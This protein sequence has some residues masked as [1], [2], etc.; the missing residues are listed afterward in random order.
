MASLITRLLSRFKT[1][2]RSRRNR[3]QL[4]RRL[5]V[6]HMEARR[7][8]AGDLG[9]IAGNVF[10][11]LADDGYQVSDVGIAGVTVSLFQDAPGAGAGT[12]GAEDGA[13]IQTNVTD[14]NGNYRFNGLSSIDDTTD[15]LY[16]VQQSAATGKL[17]R[18]AES[19]KS[20]TITPAM[21]NG[22]EATNIDTY[23]TTPV[24]TSPL[25]AGPGGTASDQATTAAGEALGGERDIQVN[26]TTVL[27]SGSQNL[28]VAV[29]GGLLSIS[30]DFGVTGSVIVSYDGV[31]LSADTLDHTT[32]PLTDLTA[33][34]GEAFEFLVGSQPGNSLTVSV[35]SGGTNFS[36][37]TVPLP[38]TSVGPPQVNLIIPFA[39]LVVAGGTGVTLTGVTA[40]RFQVDVAAGQDAQI[41]FTSVVAADVTTRNFANLNPMSL[42]N[43]VFRD[44]NNNGMKDAGDPGIPGVRVELYEDTNANGTYDTGI[45]TAVGTAQTTDA[46]GNYLFSNLLPG[47]YIALVPIS[48]FAAGQALEGL[49]TSTGND[50]TPDPDINVS[51]N[52]DN[53]A[54]IAGVGVATAAITLASGTE[55]TNDGD[56]DNNSNLTLDF[57]FAPQ[58]DLGVVKTANVTTV[59]AGNQ[60]TYTL[61]VTNAGP[62]AATNVVVTDNL[63]N[64]SPDALVIVSATA[65]GGGV[66]TQPGNANG[67]VE[68][69]YASL[70]AGQTETVTIIVRV[71]AAAAA[72]AAITN[73]ATIIGEGVEPTPDNVNIN[74]DSLDVAVTRQAVLTLT[75]TDAPDPSTVGGTLTYTILVT[76]TGPSTATNVVVSDT[77]PAGLTYVSSDTTA[78]AVAHATGVITATIPTLA[79]SASATVTIVT[80]IQASFAGSTIPNSAT[81]QADDAAQ[82]TANATTAVNPDIDLQ[83][84][85]DDDVDPVNRGGV[86]VYTLTVFNDGPSGA[87]NVE[88]VDTLPAGVTFVS[89]TGGTVTGGTVGTNGPVT[90]DLGSMASKQ[91]KVI[92]LTV[93]VAS[94]AAASI[95]N[96]AI[97]RS[98]ESTAGFDRDTTNNTATEPTA[99]Q[100]TIDLELTKTASAASVKPGQSLVYTI[101]VTNKGPSDATLVSLTDNIPDGIRITS[102]TSTVGTVTIPASAQDTTAANADD[103]T[104]NIGNLVKDATVTI[105]VN[106]TVLPGTTGSITNTANVSTTDTS[107]IETITANNTGS[108]TTTLTPEID[109]AIT[110]TD[111]VDPATAGSPLTYTITVTNSGPST[112]TNVNVTDNLPTGVSFTSGSASQGTVS[113]A[114]GV[115]TGNLGTLAPGASATMTIIVGV[116]AATRGTIT[117]TV[118]VVGAETEPITNNNS[119]SQDTVING[120]VDLV[121]TKVD[122][123][124]PVA[125]GGALS[126]TIEVTNNG[127]S[128]ATNVVV[129]DNLPTTLA[130]VSGNSTVGTVTNAGN[131]VT[132]NVGT[133]ASGAKAIITVNTTVSGTATGTITNT[134]SVVAA[135]AESNTAN[136]SATQTT[137]LV[138]PGSISGFAY[139]DVNRNGTRDNG[140]TPLPNVAVALSGTE[141]G[142]GTAVTRQTTTDANGAYTFSNLLPGTYQ[143]VQ[144]QPTEYKDGQTNVGTGATGLAGTNQITT[145]QLGSGANAQAFNFGEL[146]P[147]LSKRRFLASS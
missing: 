43:L 56:T 79:P 37:V 119:A 18:T 53:G 96:S 20:V 107:L 93:N 112:A 31:D 103:L 128:T 136:N 77:L 38:D 135:E 106:A 66:V 87:T 120:S 63:P 111:S 90:I 15:Q 134:A 34:D 75:K 41:N 65:T 91:T 100:G 35:Y 69:R 94:N 78:G 16:F 98:T 12:L 145:I 85:K 29:S 140:D 104:L 88:V 44:N 62:A 13:A 143:I 123:I 132:A 23:N 127:P 95:S 97:V 89:A 138:T 22:V 118:S 60:I 26:N 50:P 115:V 46:N 84:T 105:T 49:L 99:T 126:Y 67:E 58:I 70:A 3:R 10:T 57:G 54:L 36:S 76:N 28:D 14:A 108:V 92:T 11:D 116:N 64:L 125:V 73:T 74:T 144:T 55:P 4:D 9:S 68:I 45:D 124:D 83:I 61:T 72:A 25:R 82:V 48:Q 7:L 122:S 59:Q 130:Y 2:K 8:M 110:K 109:L 51:D 117:N 30:P 17:Q 32:L 6:E 42:G 21:A 27:T 146:Q 113:N 81:A 33:N 102:A 129:T 114:A 121:I 71:P 139:L 80:T 40:V 131:A 52:D 39:D 47:A 5:R 101:V 137:A 86:L 142:T 141:T 19:L 24:T 133:L 1:Q 147:D